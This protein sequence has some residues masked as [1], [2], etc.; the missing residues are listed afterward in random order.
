M[1]FER[2]PTD[3]ETIGVGTFDDALHIKTHATFGGLED[4]RRLLKRFFK[5]GIL[6]FENINLSDF[7]NHLPPHSTTG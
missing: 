3:H 7:V 5:S 6:P 4:A 2:L 1:V